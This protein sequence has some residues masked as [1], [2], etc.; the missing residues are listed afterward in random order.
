MR[1]ISSSSLKWRYTSTLEAI[2]MHST[3]HLTRSRRHVVTVLIF[4]FLAIGMWLSVQVRIVRERKLVRQLLEERNTG[5]DGLPSF[6]PA[7]SQKTL[8]WIRRILGDTTTA[9]VY[10]NE[11]V[12]TVDDISRIKQAYP[13]IRFEIVSP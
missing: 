12:L 1:S 5:V 10:L 8:P 4:A 13:E 2:G 11:D 9:G 3:K 7:G 6:M